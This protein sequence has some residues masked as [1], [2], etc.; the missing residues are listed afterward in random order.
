MHGYFGVLVSVSADGVYSICT[1]LMMY[2]DPA[3]ATV[4]SDEVAIEAWAPSSAPLSSAEPVGA[5][6]PLPCTITA[7]IFCSET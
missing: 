5:G 3:G 4:L 6:M 2:V 7:F 1:K